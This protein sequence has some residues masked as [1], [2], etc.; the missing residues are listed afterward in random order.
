MNY[1]PL[2]HSA[3]ALARAIAA[4]LSGTKTIILDLVRQ[5]KSSCWMFTIEITET[6]STSSSGLNWKEIPHSLDWATANSF[7]IRLKV[8]RHRIV[9]VTSD[10]MTYL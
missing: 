3:T 1:T 9:E 4:G 10:A 5:M 8:E 6:A 2:D 7:H